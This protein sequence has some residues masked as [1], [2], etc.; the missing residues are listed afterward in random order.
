MATRLFKPHKL[1][2]IPDAQW[3]AMTDD[4]RQTLSLSVQGGFTPKV[5]VTTTN[6]QTK[7]EVPVADPKTQPLTNI[8]DWTESVDGILG[9]RLRNCINFQLDVR[10]KDFWVRNMSVAHV[11]RFAKSLDEETPPG[12]TP[13]EENPLIL[14]KTKGDDKIITITRELQSEEE[15]V[16]IRNRFGITAYTI[17]FLKKKDC[18]KCKGAGNY[19][20]SSYPGQG[21][22]EKL[23][24]T[25]TCECVFE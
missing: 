23:T 16:L 19:K 3:E 1:R 10:K 4:E 20:M 11:R 6:G 18:P 9:E 22:L 5:T 8:R 13:P 2:H 25:V 7:V 21:R 14:E 17:L 24:E 15:R 12:W